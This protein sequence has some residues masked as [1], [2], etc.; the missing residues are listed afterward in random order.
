MKEEQ[1]HEQFREQG[2]N[3]PAKHFSKAMLAAWGDSTE[4]DEGTE[5][6]DAAVTL[7]AGSETESDYDSLDN[8]AQL[9]DK[10]RGLNKAKLE[11]LLVT[12][13]D[14]YGAINSENCMLKDACFELKREI[15]ELEHEKKNP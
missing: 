11:E 13:M 15:R 7:M 4:N 14:E 1:E 5:E 3:S 6:E 12:L 10:V 2:E 8:L 9:K